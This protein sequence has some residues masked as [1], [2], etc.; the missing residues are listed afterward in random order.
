MSLLADFIYLSEAVNLALSR[1]YR[2]EDAERK[3]AREIAHGH[4]GESGH[5]AQLLL[6]TD[7]PVDSLADPSWKE[8]PKLN[9]DTSEIELPTRYPD[10]RLPPGRRLLLARSI[11][12]TRKRRIEWCAIK[13]S[14]SCVDMVFPEQMDTGI[15]E[16]N[17]RSTKSGISTT[18]NLKAERDCRSWIAEIASNSPVRPRKSDMRELAIKKFSPNLSAIAFDRAWAVSAPEAWRRHGRPNK[19]GQD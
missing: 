16:T 13:I 12:A 2:R 6:P 9:F 10:R 14:A 3:L 19:T 8:N 17:K 5:G 7:P 15:I 4:F 18:A 11:P 1:G